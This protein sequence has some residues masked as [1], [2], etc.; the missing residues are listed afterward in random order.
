MGMDRAE[1]SVNYRL[2]VHYYNMNRYQQAKEHLE[3]AL[4]EDP[5]DTDALFWMSYS[6]YC[7]K[8]YEEAHR[9]CRDIIQKGMM[10]ENV[11]ELL[12][13]ILL[14][15]KKWYE[16]EQAFLQAISLNPVEADVIANY[17]YL[18]IETG[19][20]KKA[21]MLLAEAKRIDSMNSLVLHCQFYLDLIHNRKKQQ[22]ESLMAYIQIADD[23]RSKLQTIGEA[24]YFRGDY[25]IAKENLIQAFLLDPNNSR[26]KELLDSIDRVTHIVFLPNRIVKKLGGTLVAWVLSLALILLTIL[27]ARP[28]V[29]DVA[30]FLFLFNVYTWIS[31]FIY[32]LVTKA[33]VQRE[34]N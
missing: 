28:Y 2:G 25:R 27:I 19:H 18:M 14:A 1:K 13:V 34:E 17:A 16:A 30:V 10:T 20:L 11:Y 15:E 12:G 26:V 5:N 4:A 6:E 3:K 33:G 31:P 29:R 22:Q 21:K 8:N 23:E 32:N 7:L 24:A 9:L